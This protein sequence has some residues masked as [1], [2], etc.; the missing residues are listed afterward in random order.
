MARMDVDAAGAGA[1]TVRAGAGADT[2]RVSAG[3]ACGDAVQVDEDA[4]TVRVSAGDT[5]GDAVQVDAGAA[6]ADA[7]A[8]AGVV[9]GDVAQ[10]GV[11]ASWSDADERFMREALKCA[12]RAYSKGEAPVGAVVV[13][14]GAIIA[15]AYNE[16]EAKQD[17]TLHAEL[18]AIRRACKK[19]GLWRLSGCELYVTLEPCAMCA[20]AIVL[21]RIDRVVF[22]TADPKAG[23][24]GTVM[25]VLSEPALNH[26][27]AV[28]SGVLRD[29]CAGLLSGFF[30]EL[31]IRAREREG[32]EASVGAGAGVKNRSE[33]I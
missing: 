7:N 13:K 32:V 3:D 17:A 8:D 11:G 1:N 14:D 29:E 4:D 12:R 24:C 30:A 31:R 10:A 2:V 9:C 22:G 28:A 23:A 20:G 27:P 25:N 16:R 21:A 19:V 15:R 18:T 26:K 33:R 5:C 6:R